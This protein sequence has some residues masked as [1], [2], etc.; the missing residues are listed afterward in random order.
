VKRFFIRPYVAIVGT[1]FSRVKLPLSRLVDRTR[2]RS[3]TLNLPHFGSVEEYAIWMQDHLRWRAD[4]LGGLLDVFPSVE[5]VAWQLENRGVIADDCDGLALVAA[6]GALQ[7]ADFPVDVYI[8]TTVLDPEKLP[9]TRAA[10]AICVFCR[11]SKWYVVS[12]GRIDARQYAS[13]WEAVAQNEYAQGHEVKFL[14]ARDADLK[15]V[16][17]PDR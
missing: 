3:G 12:N 8:V 14:E 13:F 5:H 4:R 7:L 17:P 11:Q 6:R 16:V 10:H 9:V 2:P 1:Y 15:R